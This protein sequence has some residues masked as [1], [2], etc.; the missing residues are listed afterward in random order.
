M[1]TTSKL[2]AAVTV[3]AVA[4][5]GALLVTLGCNTQTSADNAVG[6][7]A[8][9]EEPRPPTFTS[10]GELI[11]TRFKASIMKVVMENLPGLRQTYNQALR[12]AETADLAGQIVVKFAIDEH[13]KVISSTTVPSV[14]PGTGNAAFDKSIADQV[15]TWQ[16]EPIDK[17]GDVTEVVYPF[18]FS[19]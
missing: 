11:G 7:L 4:I 15:A 17:Q 16:F 13:G 6:T 19:R 12:Q 9:V 14:K 8:A 1:K 2:A 5:T 10:G 3:A 18:E